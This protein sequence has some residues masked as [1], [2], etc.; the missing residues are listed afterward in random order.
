MLQ[1]GLL[2]LDAY[3]KIILPNL[4]MEKKRALKQKGIVELSDIP[5]IKDQYNSQVP[6]AENCV[7]GKGTSQG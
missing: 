2:F 3:D 5:T 4:K 6:F 7:F 1:N